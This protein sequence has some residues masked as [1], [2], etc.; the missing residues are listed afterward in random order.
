MFNYLAVMNG[1]FTM[2]LTQNMMENH[3]HLKHVLKEGFAIH[4]QD[5]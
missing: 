3:I 1:N 4:H 5:G 2:L